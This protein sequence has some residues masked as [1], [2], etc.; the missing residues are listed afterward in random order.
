MAKTVD[1]HSKS[2]AEPVGAFPHA[3]RVG[4]L[5]FVSGIGPRMKG[6]REVPGVQ[7]SAQGE[8]LSYDF[9]VQYRQ[10]LKNVEDVLSDAGLTLKDLVDVTC[11]LT[12]MKQDFP[13]YNQMWRETFRDASPCRTT[14]EVLSLPT[15]IAIEFKC[16]AAFP[17]GQER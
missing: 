17:S 5:L 14:V 1:V 3:K 13:R 10:V 12:N 2:A 7:L 6:V 8:V 11:F 15:P 16:V 9:E 4:Q